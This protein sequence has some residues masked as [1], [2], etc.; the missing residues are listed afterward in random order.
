[1][2]IRDKVVAGKSDSAAASRLAGPPCEWGA[3]FGRADARLT[4]V[5]A[6]GGV[7][8]EIRCQ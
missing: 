7:P 3:D 2:S 4:Q 5:Y 1:M 8:Q 6:L